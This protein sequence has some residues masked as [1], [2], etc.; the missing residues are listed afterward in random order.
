MILDLWMHT[1]TFLEKRFLVSKKEDILIC[2]DKEF[3]RK[4]IKEL[5]E[6]DEAE[7]EKLLNEFSK[8]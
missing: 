7:L 2:L 5:L 4:I 3:A 6:K 8:L 1:L